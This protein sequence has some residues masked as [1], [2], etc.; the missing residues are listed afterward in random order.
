MPPSLFVV[1]K[2]DLIQ[3]EEQAEVERAGILLVSAKTG[4]GIDELCEA[5]GRRLQEEYG[6]ADGIPLTS[7]QEEA[8]RRIQ[9]GADQANAALSNR[10]PE[11]ATQ[12]LKDALS[13]VA[14][15]L[16]E[17]VETDVLD[18]IFSEF[19]IGK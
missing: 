9:K 2:V 18:R 13:G 11:L 1:N 19:C 8:L 3:E 16:G 6:P 5:L 12:D 17:G 14:D 10:Q 4:R 7:R 15:I